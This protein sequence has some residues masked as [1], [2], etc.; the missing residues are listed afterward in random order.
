MALSEWIA[1]AINI[2]LAVY[3]VWYY[4]RTLKRMF[5]ARPMPRGFVL[6][7]LFIRYVGI[8]ALAGTALY[9]LLR[10][11]GAYSGV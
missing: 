11:T 10:L 7:R 5:G 2:L 4:P 3:F 6:L 9:V 1:V 8:V